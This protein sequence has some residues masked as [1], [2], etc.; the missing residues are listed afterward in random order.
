MVRELKSKIIEIVNCVPR[1]K[2]TNYGTIATVVNI[3]LWTSVS[4]QLIWWQLNW[5]WSK[6]C[7]RQRIVSKKWQISALKLWDKWVRQIALLKKE[8]VFVDQEN[9]VDMNVYWYYFPEILS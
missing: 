5:L 9:K 8:W 2:V 3:L 7:E 1:W 4:A 6:D